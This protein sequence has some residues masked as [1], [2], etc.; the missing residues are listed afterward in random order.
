MLT[1]CVYPD[2]YS[3][4]YDNQGQVYGQRE[5]YACGALSPNYPVPA[6]YFNHAKVCYHGMVYAYNPRKPWWL[7]R[8]K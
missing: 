5:A 1:L 4:V 7:S 3:A 6:L 8:G 2:G